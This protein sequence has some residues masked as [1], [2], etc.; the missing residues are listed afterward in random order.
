MPECAFCQIVSGESE[1]S[2]VFQ[3]EHS[4]AFLDSRP[5]FAGH[6]LLVPREH[7]E[8]L[9]DLPSHLLEPLFSNA[10]LLCRAVEKAMQAQGTFVA[11]NNKISQSVPHLHIHIVPR[12]KKDGL[13]GF[14]WPRNPYRDQEHMRSTAVRLRKELERLS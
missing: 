8:V 2:R 1:A 12:N 9:A 11:I 3:D 6:L 4:V 13:R 7:Y 14:F 5:L 10:Q